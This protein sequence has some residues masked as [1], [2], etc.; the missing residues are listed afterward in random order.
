MQLNIQDG[1]NDLITSN[2]N[3]QQMIKL[4]TKGTNT[5]NFK[6]HNKT[7]Q[8]TDGKEKHNFLTKTFRGS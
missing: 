1:T 2:N 5:G 8:G 3:T 6:C 4:L 7:G